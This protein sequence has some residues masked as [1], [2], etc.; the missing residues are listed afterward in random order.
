M[1][2]F[3]E[4]AIGT[5]GGPSCRRCAPAVPAQVLREADDIAADIAAVARTW[6][7]PLG[8]NVTFT[9]AEPFAH[10]ALPKLIAQAR[11]AGFER[12]GLVTDAGALAFGDNAI[13]AIHT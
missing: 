1:I 5:G 12:I 13:G 2:Q 10:D 6:D 3:E 8:P 11:R 9:G 4:I 7:S